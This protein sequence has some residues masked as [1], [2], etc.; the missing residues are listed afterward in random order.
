M[1][2]TDQTRRRNSNDSNRAPTVTSKAKILKEW[3]A[4][5]GTSSNQFIYVPQFLSEVLDGLQE[6]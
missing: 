5:H 1:E 4:K 2:Q 3:G 6:R